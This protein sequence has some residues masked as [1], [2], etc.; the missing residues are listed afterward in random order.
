MRGYLV[1]EQG[2]LYL[3]GRKATSRVVKGV[4]KPKFKEA[5]KSVKG[6]KVVSKKYVSKK[7]AVKHSKKQT[8]ASIKK[9]RAAA[10]KSAGPAATPKKPTGLAT[11]PKTPARLTKTAEKA[12]KA[13][14]EIQEASTPTTRSKSSSDSGIA[15][16]LR[17]HVKEIKKE[18]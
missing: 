7:S 18:I 8:Y 6:R 16:R 3:I 1:S 5:P 4:T 9:G 13:A 2:L 12:A 17:S 10:K 11:T 15:L 14:M